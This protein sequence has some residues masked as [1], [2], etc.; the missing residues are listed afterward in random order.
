M[1]L[2]YII[3]VILFTTLLGTV[4]VNGQTAATLYFMEEVAERNNMNPAFTPNCKFYFDF[5]I[6]PNFYLDL[7]NNSLTLSDLLYLN[8]GNT[9]TPLNSPASIDKFYRTLQPT[10]TISTN[11]ALNLLSFGFQVKERGYF[12]F[13]LGLHV[14]A[15][16]YL[17][18]DMFKLLLYGTPDAYG[19]NSFNLS[20]L[21]VGADV[22]SSLGVGYMHKINDQ[23]TVGGK[24]KALMGYANLSTNFKNLDLNA[25]SD[26]WNVKIDG[27][28]KGSVPLEFDRTNDGQLD[29]ESMEVPDISSLLSLLYLPAGFGGAIDLGV[30][31]KPIKDLT[32][33][34]AI[35]D[36]GFIHWRKNLVTASVSD[37][38]YEVDGL[39][40]DSNLNDFVDGN[41]GMDTALLG[42][43]VDGLLDATSATVGNAYNSMIY[44]NFAVGAE[45]GVL[46]NKISFGLM[47]RLRFNNSYAQNELT[48]ALNLRPLNWIKT[49]F[50]YTYVNSFA[51]NIGAGLNFRVGALNMYLI[52]DFVPL[53]YATLV[54]NGEN[55]PYPI[56]Y[57]TERITLQAGMAL[58]IGRYSNDM[59][60]DGV[61]KY[62]DKCPNTDMNFLMKQCPDLSKKQLV[63][64]KGCDLD[65][66]KDGIHDCYDKCPDTPNGVEV[67]S[68]GCP[69]DTDNDGI[70][71]YLD[72]CPDSPEAVEVDSLGCPIDT[73]NDGVADYLD[74]CSNT[75]EGVEVDSIGCPVDTDNDGVA[76][77]LDKC[78]NTPKGATVDTNGCPLDTDK[79]GVPDYLDRCPNTPLNSMIDENGCPIDADGDGVTDYLD[80]CPDTPANVE[81]DSVGCPVDT[82]EDGVPDY[83]DKCPDKAGTETNE[84]CP[85]ITKEVRNLF[86][87]AMSGIEFESGKDIIKK[88]SYPILDQIVS[89]LELS[90]EYNLTI[91]GHTD[92][93]G[94]D[95]LN[96]K[97]STDRAAAVRNYLIEKGVAE[98]R[99]KSQGF[100][101]TQP[102]ASNK[103]AK[104]RAKNRRVEFEITYEVVTYEKVQNP[105]LMDSTTISNDSIAPTDSIK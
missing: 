19:V 31:Y 26:E 22:Y 79:D 105:E 28:I 34:A 46:D 37:Y 15:N 73:D 38:T 98:T 51:S 27:Q 39:I 10:T 43:F 61:K 72:K 55:I 17:P 5:I 90:T 101:E 48:V 30:T 53:S 81:V 89:I 6:M 96:M 67:D 58:N 33:S 70:A 78:P 94:N 92:N 18:K 63:D 44:A 59:D 8:N 41:V 85:E 97:L 71:D 25:S 40:D 2:K 42:N 88:S 9:L 74:K 57:N 77:Y 100:G 87:K 84:G 24:L 11:V 4:K 66:D 36:L 35:T 69:F 93:V 65:N 103:T 95:D 54:S 82:D 14:N 91:S 68:L 76:D 12:T 29:L 47:D 20:S 21:G 60:N 62:R 1:K 52:A 7:G 23:W 64:K 83:L 13:D 49:T 32:V 104:G 16:A 80:K 45:Y 102:I 56:P 50:S 75:P 99:L 86:T 3:T